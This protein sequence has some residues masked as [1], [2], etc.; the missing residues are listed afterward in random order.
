MR[1]SWVPPS[2]GMCPE[3]APHALQKFLAH[4]S[5]SGAGRRPPLLEHWHFF[6]GT[7]WVGSGLGS[8]KAVGRLPG[9]T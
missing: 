8:A 3:I 7:L 6:P 9:L 4:H 1:G 5:Q 2:S